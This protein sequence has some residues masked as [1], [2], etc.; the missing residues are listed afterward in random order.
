MSSCSLDFAS[1]TCTPCRGGVPPMTETEAHAFAKDVPDWELLDNAT[2]MRRRF[3]FKDFAAAFAFVGKVAELSE[4]E[5]HHPDI[6][7][8]WGYAEVLLF[9]HK[10][11]GLHENDFIMAAKYDRAFA[12]GC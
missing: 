1:K 2:R 4:H 5:G 7:F 11:N 6:T 8:G 9:T 3:A 12:G 10:I